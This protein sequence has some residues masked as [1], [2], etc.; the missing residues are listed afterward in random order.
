MKLNSVRVQLGPR[1]HWEQLCSD[2]PTN[3]LGYVI[4][5]VG[6]S[7]WFRVIKPIEDNNREAIIDTPHET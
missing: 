7:I 6:T 3:T 4:A 1:K 2:N 5:K